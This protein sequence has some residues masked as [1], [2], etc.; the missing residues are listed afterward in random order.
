[1]ARKLLAGTLRMGHV[2]NDDG[3]SEVVIVQLDA[4][5]AI[6]TRPRSNPG[7]D[8]FRM[9][10]DDPP[11]APDPLHFYDHEG[12]LTLL[13]C[14]N[15][16]TTASTGGA[17]VERIRATRVVASGRDAIPYDAVNGMRVEID[18]LAT[19][20]EMTTVQQSL[21]RT[22]DESLAVLI[23]ADNPDPILLG[24]PLNVSLETTFTHNP[25][26][27]GNVF[28]VT[29]IVSVRT[30]S[31]ELVAWENHA[32][33]HRM[34]QDLMCLVYA[35][36]CSAELTAVMRD[37]DQAYSDSSEKRF[38]H[39]AYQPSFGRGSAAVRPLDRTRD[40]PLF[41][42]RDLDESALQSWMA[43][44]D[45]WSR[46]TWI[47]VTT[48]FQQGT[49]IEAKLLQIGVA[50]E[51]LGFAIW[52]AERNSRGGA[53]PNFP[54]LLERVTDAVGFHHNR[55]YGEADART[56]RR[57]FNE[58]FKGSKHADRPLPDALAARDFAAQGLNLIRAWLAVRLG[59][60]TDRLIERMER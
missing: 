13:E 58:A 46:P 21:E 47:A 57:D 60:D 39:E 32:V 30:R 16:G 24:G 17:S 12:R 1:M 2:K 33:V 19:W 3:T 22:G 54:R 43:E 4:K 51:S 11:A 8:P 59:V 52:T 48:M 55:L 26:P 45:L 44:W 35:K 6:A 10:T 20:A 25:R 7:L 5:G 36:P 29:D 53:T 9:L 28:S 56:W 42:L 15:V 14:R 49:T 23:R 38:W 50:L 37:D 31:A 40:R 27:T 34:L 41:Y 18:G